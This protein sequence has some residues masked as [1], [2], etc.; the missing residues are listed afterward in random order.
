MHPPD[1]KMLETNSG[2]RSS[3]GSFGGKAQATS[4][5]STIGSSTSQIVVMAG[6]WITYDFGA[7]DFKIDNDRMGRAVDCSTI[8][9]ICGLKDSILAAYGLL[10]REIEV[11][12]CYWLIDGDSEMVGKRAAPVEIS[13]DT[14]YKIFKMLGLPCRHAIAASSYRNMEYSF[15][16]SQ[17]HVKDTW[18]ETVKGII[19]PIPNPEDIHIPA[20]ILK[21]QLFPPM[22]KR[23]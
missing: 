9:G 16:V 8:K 15:F 4:S 22:T 14:D 18:S 20:D 11:E 13:T 23:T 2:L 17:Y 3:D 10:G 6:R 12:M 7:W 5:N 19:L 21:L 1:L